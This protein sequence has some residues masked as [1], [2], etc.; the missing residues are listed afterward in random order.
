ME[1]PYAMKNSAVI[2][3]ESAPGVSRSRTLAAGGIAVIL[4]VALWCAWVLLIGA[5][6]CALSYL[7]W[8]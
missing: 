5:R 7:W 2:D 3:L 4:F 1:E 6:P 8:R